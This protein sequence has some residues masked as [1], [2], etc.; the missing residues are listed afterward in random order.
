MD[1]NS[2]QDLPVQL[3]P[4]YFQYA[5]DTIVCSRGSNDTQSKAIK[6]VG[7]YS[8]IVRMAA[9]DRELTHAKIAE[10]IGT[11]RPSETARI[12]QASSA[13][14]GNTA[15]GSG[16]ANQSHGINAGRDMKNGI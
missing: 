15:E 13:R 16:Y 5:V 7:L 12:S 11:T 9:E 10:R 1:V 6:C 8:V 2:R 4:V 14:F 3:G